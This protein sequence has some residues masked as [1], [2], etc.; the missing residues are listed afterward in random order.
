MQTSRL[1][2]RLDLREVDVV[3]ILDGLQLDD[4]PAFDDQVELVQ[5][6]LFFLEEDADL[7]LVVEDNSPIPQGDFHCLLIN[8]L[9]KPRPKCLVNGYRGLQDLPG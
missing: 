1:E 4:D 6:H 3:Q 9:Q 5:S 2:V 7:F 8:T